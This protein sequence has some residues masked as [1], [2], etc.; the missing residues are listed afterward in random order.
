MNSNSM[1]LT[2]N[3]GLRYIYTYIYQI[4]EY[5]YI[6]GNYYFI[7]IYNNTVCLK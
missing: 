5:T 2:K 7:P 1:L 6:E 4:H 3:I